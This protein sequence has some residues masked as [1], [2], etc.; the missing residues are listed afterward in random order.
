MKRL[1][2]V[3][4]SWWLFGRAHSGWILLCT[5]APAKLLS[6][7]GWALG[8]RASG[9]PQRWWGC[10]RRARA[11][12]SFWDSRP[13]VHGSVLRAGYQWGTCTLGNHVV[14]NP[15]R[16]SKLIGTRARPS[17]FHVLCNQVPCLDQ[18]FFPVFC[19]APV[20]LEHA[21]PGSIPFGLQLS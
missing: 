11:A 3:F 6:G 21:W 10:Q 5:L 19:L 2:E 14:N 12:K 7:H 8:G 16:P 4:W 18:H 1:P 13:L 17:L 15:R 20:N 9:E